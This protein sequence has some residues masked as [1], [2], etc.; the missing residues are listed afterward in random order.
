M[1]PL[2]HVE[3]L[4]K[5]YTK[6][7][8]PALVDVSFSVA[9]GESFALYGRSGAGK[10]TLL[11]ILA[12]LSAKSHGR[13]TI[14]G[15]DLDQQAASIR[16]EVGVVGAAMPFDLTLTA[17]ENLRL[18]VCRHE[19]YVYH[20]HYQQ[21]SVHYRQR[22]AA[23]AT[24]LECDLFQPVARFSP[25][26]QRKLAMARSLLHDP[27]LVLLDEPTAGLDPQS[28]RVFWRYV[29]TQRWRKGFTLVLATANLAETGEADRVGLLQYGELLFEAE[30]Q[31][32]RSLSKS[33][34]YDEEHL[35]EVANKRKPVHKRCSA[36]VAVRRVWRPN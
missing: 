7:S 31:L 4:V 11:A 29:H 36:G 6:S 9:A 16:Q 17:E 8:Q 2:L 28:R 12:T 33:I 35:Y 18:H 26:L 19:L 5:Q 23:L 22:I 14:A 34:L 10:S 32:M 21:M 13:V 24:E 30:S 20:D 3:H 1:R 25:L 27:L 15:C